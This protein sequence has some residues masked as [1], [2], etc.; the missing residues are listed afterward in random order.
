MYVLI[1]STRTRRVA[2]IPNGTYTLGSFLS[3]LKNALQAAVPERTFTVSSTNPSS[4]TTT[5]TITVTGGG[6]DFAWT[7][8]SASEVLG[9]GG[10][11]NTTGY[12]SVF[13]GVAPPKLAGDDCLYILSNIGGNTYLF[14][15][16]SYRVLAKVRLD[17]NPGTLVV[18]TNAHHIDYIPTALPYIDTIELGLMDTRGN[19]LSY[20]CEWS[21][22]LVVRSLP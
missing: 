19:F 6:V 14:S 4:L 5:I 2:S 10:Q 17:Q 13:T 16:Q 1:A 18:N 22:T 11:A 12:L 7:E 3:V 21:L 9:F 20:P 8:S 15:N